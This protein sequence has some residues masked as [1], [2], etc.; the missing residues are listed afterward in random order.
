MLFAVATRLQSRELSSRLGQLVPTSLVVSLQP[1][2]V[3]LVASQLSSLGRT[4]LLQGFI[5]SGPALAGVEINV[6]RGQKLAAR[7]RFGIVAPPTLREMRPGEVAV[8]EPILFDATAVEAIGV[9]EM[10]NIVDA[11]YPST[12]LEGAKQVGVY[13]ES[14]GFRQGDTVDVSVQIERV[15]QLSKVRRIGLAFRVTTDPNFTVTAR[16]TEPQ[17]GR[18][19]QVIPGMIPILARHITQNISQL[20]GGTYRLRVAMQRKNGELVSADR[21][22]QLT[23]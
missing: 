5:P 1:D 9:S 15:N 6:E 22:F 13:W 4:A 16:W 2:S 3:Q 23:R 20:P 7:S 17:P 18:S 14:Y 21:L 19:S 12:V 11:M 8:S 10:G